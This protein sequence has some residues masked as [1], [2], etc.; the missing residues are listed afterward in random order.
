MKHTMSLSLES[1]LRLGWAF[2]RVMAGKLRGT[3]QQ[4]PRFMAQYAPDGIVPFAPEDPSVLEG[5]SRCIACGRCDARALID[6]TFHALGPRGPMAFVL[7]VSRHSGRHDAAEISSTI[8]TQS[9]NAL[10]AACPVAVPFA[11]LVD[12]VRRRQRALE[13][14]RAAMVS[15]SSTSMVDGNRSLPVLVAAGSDQP[16]R[17]A[18]AA[19]RR[20]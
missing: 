2:V 1:Y 8:T 10:T 20:R 3:H 12:L 18:H 13:A 19:L 14:S 15:T 7:G 9:L 5:A 16:H 11:A 6:G 17:P 4:L